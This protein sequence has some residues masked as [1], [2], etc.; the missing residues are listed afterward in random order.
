MNKHLGL[1]FVAVGLVTL[2][3]CQL[4]DDLPPDVP[5]SSSQESL[6]IEPGQN[7]IHSSNGKVQ[8]APVLE[9]LYTKASLAGFSESLV[10]HQL[11]VG[12][13]RQLRVLKYQRRKRPYQ[14]DDVE[15][16]LSQLE[17]SIQTILDVAQNNPEMMADFLDAY[18]L[19]GA[20]SKGNVKFTGYYTPILKV[21]REANAEYKYPIYTRPDSWE[22]RLPSREEIDTD[23][24][25]K[26]KGLELAYARNLVDIYF[27]Q[28][29]GSGIVEFEDGRQVLFANN[30]DNKYNYSS[31]GRYMVRKG[32]VTEA[33]TS[34]RSIRRYLGEHPELMAEVLNSNKSYVFFTPVKSKPKGAGLV[35]LLADYSIAVDRRFIPM[36]SCLL[37]RV[38]VIHRNKVT[39]H[40]YRV[41]LAQDVGGAIKGPGHI[42]VYMGVGEKA[43]R[44]ASS[45]H[46]YGNLWL[47][48]PK[49]NA[50]LALAN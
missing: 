32:Y 20:D 35:Q 30:G 9:E 11:V 40:E 33:E 12:L 24:V 48:L 17:Q 22:G 39:H 19:K 26:D 31:V 4:D 15:V 28:V 16:Q 8:D 36:G 10:N 46:H 13:K 42:D 18:Q 6:L 3:A 25:L 49:D 34:L 27:M 23:G 14:F 21:R 29:Q 43:R 5:N 45:M 41:L 37:A 47:L 38:P 7:Y 50:P 1:L 2:C 44:K